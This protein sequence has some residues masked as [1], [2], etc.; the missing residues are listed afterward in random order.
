M[1]DGVAQQALTK[2]IRASSGDVLLQI[3]TDE[4]EDFALQALLWCY[5][6]VET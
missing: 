6:C 2:S 4:L 3:D 1:H 5:G